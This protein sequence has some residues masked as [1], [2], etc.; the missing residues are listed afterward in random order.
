MDALS[1]QENEQVNLAALSAVEMARVLSA[2][3]GRPV[4]A[5]VVQAD[6]DAGA[7]VDS[8]GRLNLLSYTAWLAKQAQ[9]MGH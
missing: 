1:T 6:V 4:D 3:G 9:E 5:A 2:A 7:P 8:D